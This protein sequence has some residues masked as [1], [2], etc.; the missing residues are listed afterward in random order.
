MEKSGFHRVI[1]VLSTKSLQLRSTASAA[2]WDSE[3]N[4]KKAMENYEREK[5]QKK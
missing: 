4:C 5:E 1:A 2:T 3:Q